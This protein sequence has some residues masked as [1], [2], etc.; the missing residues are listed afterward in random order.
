MEN[1]T[2]MLLMYQRPYPH[3]GDY[4]QQTQA[5]APG[6]PPHGASVWHCI[7]EVAFHETWHI[8]LYDTG[9]IQRCSMSLKAS[10]SV[11]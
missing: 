9:V 4:Q 2:L 3:G 5:Q 6:V 8:L 10:T 7:T 11:W 1:F